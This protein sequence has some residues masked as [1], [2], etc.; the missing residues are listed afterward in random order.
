MG[1]KS[2]RY[3]EFP[4]A[5]DGVGSKSVQ[6]FDFRITR[7]LAEILLGNRP[8]SISVNNDVNAVFLDGIDELA[9]IAEDISTGIAV[10]FL[11]GIGKDA[12]STEL[13]LL[14]RPSLTHTV[15][16]RGQLFRIF[17]RFVFFRSCFQKCFHISTE[18]IHTFAVL[19]KPMHNISVVRGD[20]FAVTF[21]M[22]DDVLFRQTIFFAKV[23]AK[24]YRFLVY[25]GEVRTIGGIILADLKADVGVV[26]RTT[27][28]PASVIPGQGLV[29]SNSS[30]SKLS[31]E[32]VN[33]DISAAR[34]SRVPMIVILVFAEQAIIWTD[35]TLEVGV[36]GP[37][38]MNHNTFY[39]NGSAC[40]V[41]SILGENELM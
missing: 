10:G 12:V 39:S 28:V 33:A 25:L 38:G 24:L 37:G 18:G 29:G 20:A 35:I 23:N 19:G 7:T 34:T 21:A 15:V 5:V 27:C 17:G 22:A 8:K 36:V 13:T 41:A 6:L 3:F 4:S 26:S 9:I 14:I 40:L 2:V 16:A 31:N 32:C 1:I 30:V 11:L